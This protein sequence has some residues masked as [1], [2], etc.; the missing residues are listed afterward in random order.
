M[1]SILENRRKI[2]VFLVVSSL[3]TVGFAGCLSDDDDEPTRRIELELYDIYSRD[4]DG[5]KL[6]TI[7]LTVT[8]RV[9]EGIKNKSWEHVSVVVKDET[10][11]VSTGTLPV[12]AMP[13]TIPEGLGVY[14]VQP[15]IIFSD[16]DP[17]VETND[18]ILI[19][20]LEGRYMGG[21][22]EVLWNDKTVTTH[23]LPPDF[24]PEVDISFIDPVTHSF[25]HPKSMTWSIELDVRTMGDTPMVL[26]WHTLQVGIQRPDGT[27]LVAPM[28]LMSDPGRDGY[29]NASD[30]LV[31]IEAWYDLHLEL[32]D[33]PLTDRFFTTMSSFSSIKMTGLTRMHE[34]ALLVL[35]KGEDPIWTSAPIGPFATPSIKLGNPAMW[36]T[37]RNDTLYFNASFPITNITPH[38][39]TPSWD[40]ISVIVTDGQSYELM[41][42]SV[43]G[44]DPGGYCRTHEAWFD[45]D[46]WATGNVTI[47]ENLILKGLNLSFRGATVILMRSGETIGEGQ[48]PSI[49]GLSGMWL[50]TGS[51]DIEDRLVGNQVVYDLTFGVRSEDPYKDPLPWE[52]MEVKVVDRESEEVL[53]PLTNPELFEGVHSDVPTVF[54]DIYTIENVTDDTRFWIILSALN[55]TFEGAWL[56]LYLD[57]Q[58]ISEEWIP[59]PFNLS[60]VDIVINIAYPYV[61]QRDIDGSTYWDVVLNIN[62]ITPEHALP[63]WSDLR[64]KVISSTGSV[65]VHPIA[66]QP[67]VGVYDE[68]DSDGI[69]VELW[70]VE[71]AGDDEAS[72]GDAFKL[73][74][75]PQ[76]YEGA[77][78][79]FYH[80][81]DLVGSITLPPS[82]P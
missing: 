59:N 57:G 74:G 38:Y 17:F 11:Q 75:L 43:A 81:G 70:Y 6:W 56:E 48:L 55:E 68:D 31:D 49:F 69:D 34:F 2:A 35:F 37:V 22:V 46:T 51:P 27:V 63:A 47:G 1:V 29:D 12:E 77:T 14:Y 24:T 60:K 4:V 19:V 13:D 20:G 54:F 50:I 3:L 32:Y 39:A 25:L 40:S 42:I 67:D 82:F 73:T 9:L 58:K 7:E 26:Q 64:I 71:T 66:M 15:F 76:Y 21:V 79:E 33:G 18:T 52:E 41:N 23:D 45:G 28:A 61:S 53:L 30:G 78:L 62:K 10:G 36:S 5:T 16:G 44:Q 8:E 72:A 65:L 80:F